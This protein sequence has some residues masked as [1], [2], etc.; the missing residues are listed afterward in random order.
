MNWCSR[1]G[2]EFNAGK[3]F[4]LC[5]TKKRNAVE[6]DATYHLSGQRIESVSYMRDLGVLIDSKLSFEHHI[7]DKV[8]KAN[9][10]L[11]FL[12]RTCTRFRELR[13]LLTLYFTIVRPLLE[14]NSPVWSP[15]YDIYVRTLESVQGRFT[16]YIYRKFHYPYEPSDVRN[17]RLGLPLLSE[18]RNLND[19]LTL[20]KIVH[21][22]VD[23]H[24][25]RN[26][27]IKYSARNMRSSDTFMLQTART[28]VG[29]QEPLHR[30]CSQYNSELS[31]FD[32]FS[33]FRQ[34]KMHVAD[35]FLKV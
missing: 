25:T 21:S 19:A 9:K 35:Y 11:G 8:C 16:K 10:M 1:N 18:R 2:L 31:R 34:Y 3:S 24:L 28:N 20:H 17:K 5:I 7:R 32:I 26:I 23:T 22:N 29:V 6:V 14:Y 12:M 30:M 27:C 13:A 4:K 33:S 15:I